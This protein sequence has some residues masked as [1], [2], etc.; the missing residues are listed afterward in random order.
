MLNRSTGAGFI[1]T[2]LS[3]QTTLINTFIITFY[4]K[5]LIFIEDAMNFRF[6]VIILH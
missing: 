5:A 4:Q 2:T 6:P 3:V 1:Q